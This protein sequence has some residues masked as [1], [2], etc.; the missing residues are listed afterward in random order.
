ML[1]S[2]QTRLT[3]YVIYYI[4]SIK[5]NNLFSWVLTLSFV[6]LLCINSKGVDIMII[7]LKWGV[8]VRKRKISSGY[9]YSAINSTYNGFNEVFPEKRLKENTHHHRWVFSQNKTQMG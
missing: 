5:R 6:L 3:I 1:K 7:K 8:L 9:Y 2:E 4:I